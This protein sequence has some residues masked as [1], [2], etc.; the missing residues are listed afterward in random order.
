MRLRFSLTNVSY[1]FNHFKLLDLE[2]EIKDFFE[3]TYEKPGRMSAGT[4]CS[5]LIEFDP[6]LNKDIV[7]V[8]PVL[9]H[10]GP[11][12]IPLECYTKK[13]VPSISTASLQNKSTF[14]TDVLPSEIGN[15]QIYLQPGE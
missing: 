11:I 7:S 5:I 14:C 2:D 12:N 10:T 6:K 4:S 13:V 15:L 1:T 3:I 9:S 8:L